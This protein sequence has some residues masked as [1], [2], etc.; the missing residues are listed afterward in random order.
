MGEAVVTC[1]KCAARRTFRGTNWEVKVMA[2]MWQ[3][4][5]ER[6]GHE[7]EEVSMLPRG[8]W[9]RHSAALDSKAARAVGGNHPHKGDDT[10]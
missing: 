2:D 9:I 6:A 7:G 8:G 10:S 1:A 3:N 5:H 4:E